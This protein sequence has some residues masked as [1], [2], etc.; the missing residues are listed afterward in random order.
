MIL[1]IQSIPIPYELFESKLSRPTTYTY[2]DLSNICGADK[3]ILKIGPGNEE[4]PFP[5]DETSAFYHLSI[6]PNG[7]VYYL[8]KGGF[9][10]GLV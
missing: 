2:F 5:S 8:A 7:T 3:F 9:S 1:W 6:T 4:F 10:M